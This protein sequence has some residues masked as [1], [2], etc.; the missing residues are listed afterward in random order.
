MVAGGQGAPWFLIDATLSRI[1]D[2][3][4]V[5]Q[6]LGG[7][8]HLTLVTPPGGSLDQCSLRPGQRIGSSTRWTAA[9]QQAYDR[10]GR[11][12]TAGTPS[13]TQS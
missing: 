10:N 2:A 5:L 11:L 9:H 6:K 12:A 1:R 7:H 4:R 8:R 3:A 13:E